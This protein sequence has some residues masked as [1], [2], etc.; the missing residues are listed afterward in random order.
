MRYVYY[1]GCSLEGTA[2]EYDASTRA[3]MR[4]LGAE[5]VELED[6]TCCGASAADTV[7]HLLSMALPARNLAKAQ[8]EQDG[9]DILAPCSAC[10]LN[11]RRVED[12]IRKEEGLLERINEVLSVEG[13]SYKGGVRSRHLLDVLATD[14]GPDRIKAQVSHPLTGLRVVPYYGCQA[15]RPYRVFDDPEEPRSMEPLLQALGAKVHPWSMGARC[16][17]AGLMTTKKDAALDAV[18]NLLKAARGADCIV[19]VCP[20]CQMNLEAYQKKISR[21]QGQDLIISVLYLPQLMGLA[22]GLPASDLKTDMNFV[23]T[24]ELRSKIAS[25]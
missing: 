3:V 4:Q 16:C 17:G 10:Y 2:L 25:A 14:M 22:F 13:L 9:T 19:T 18:G 5:L 21:L 6:W 11:L 7:S 24:P 23:V 12:H 15:L 1:P 20:M 8:S